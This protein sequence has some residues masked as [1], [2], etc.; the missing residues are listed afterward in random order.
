MNTSRKV[1]VWDIW[2]RLFHWSL[3][4]LFTVAWFTGE[5]ENDLHIWA[6]YAILGL[7]VFR[8]IW[9]FVGSRHA[10]FGDFIRPPAEVVS[11]LKGL[12]SGRVRHYLGHNPAG[13]WMILAL[14]LSLSVVT[15]SGLKV[16]AIEEGKGPLAWTVSP[17]AETY[18]AAGY[19]EEWEEED[20]AME[21]EEAGE[22][23]EAGMEAGEDEEEEEF[24]EE[25][26][27][28]SVNFTLLLVFLH[29]AGVIVS[30]RLHRENL[31][32]AMIT[33]YKEPPEGS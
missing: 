14:L 17:S 5:E 2:V 15:F 23:E 1:A 33:G 4:V 13:G 28:A 8:V 30:S 32:R 3:V 20:E 25:I 12:A 11:Y 9:G 22:H 6:G 10:R 26:H 31:V 18:P 27:E 19:R 21:L 16:Y 24:W 29:I 7:L